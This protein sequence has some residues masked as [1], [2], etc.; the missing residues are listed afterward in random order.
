MKGMGKALLGREVKLQ[1]RLPAEL[2]APAHRGVGGGRSLET[3]PPPL[4]P[5]W[6]PWGEASPGGADS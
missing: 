4:P 3:A 1:C 5:M 6:L 2:S